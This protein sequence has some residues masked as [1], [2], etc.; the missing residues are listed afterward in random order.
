MT[1][2]FDP[3]TRLFRPQ[4]IA[5]IGGDWAAAALAECAKLGFE[6]ALQAVHPTRSDLAGAP[7]VREISDLPVA[8]DVAFVA[9]N[10]ERSVDAVAALR[11]IGAGGVVCFASGF[12]ETGEP[13]AAELERALVAAAG[14]MPLLGPNCYG[15]VNY[16]DR[17]CIWPDQHG[18]APATRGV[19]IVAQSSNIAI[20]LT[21]QRR[22]LPIGYMLTLGNQARLGL[23]DVA[24]A[25]LEDPRTTAL[26]LLIEGVGP[27]PRFE[28]LAARARALGKPIIALKLGRSAQAQAAALTHTASLAGSDAGADALF[29]RLGVG[30]VDTLAGFL[31][32]LKL[33]HAHGPLPGRRIA[34]M[35]CSGGEAG[36]M[37]DAP[38]LTTRTQ[39]IV[40]PPLSGAAKDGAASA[41]GP[42]VT[43][44]NPLDYHTYIWGDRAGMADAFAAVAGDGYDLTALVLDFPRSDRCDDSAWKVALDAMTDAKSRTGAR[45]AVIANLAENLPESWAADILDRG[46]APLSG[47]DSAMAAIAACA[48]VGAAWAKAPPAVLLAP[49]AADGSAAQ[50]LREDAAKDA[51][52]AFGLRCPRRIS[53]PDAAAAGAAAAL[54]GGPV[55]LKGLGAA[56]KTGAGLLRLGLVGAKA[57][58]A[59]ARDM[60]N[61]DGFLVEEMIDGA[62]AEL[63]IGCRADA[64]HG[65]VLTLGLGGV[66]TE[67]LADTTSLLLPATDAEI[68]SAWL[69]LR[70]A[71]LLTG[72]RGA[73]AADLDAV[74]AATQA[75]AAYVAAQS[76]RL[77]EVEVNPL[78]AAP[79]GAAAVDALIVLSPDDKTEV[80]P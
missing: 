4:S 33:A 78:L 62:V 72:F 43:I 5:A 3:L 23:A 68:R 42:K 77:L 80:A 48:D 64:A 1:D 58:E 38:T 6:G 65:F 18:G 29:A 75:I 74:V 70:G 61:A 2:G 41:L 46:L 11:D 59:A 67:L 30:R 8:P 73:P 27:L 36:L 32:A 20:N 60:A 40:Y 52:E 47:V 28:A 56:H 57:V 66:R 25:A 71:P 55:A 17:A 37:A 19:A 35:S 13:G 76:A 16:F 39:R 63:L 22:G 14:D 15:F 31:D 7:C 21:M 79:S 12:R 53:A 26:G 34:S 45:M 10:R 69:S 51:L 54:M 9:V 44:A 24:G 49:S 50:T